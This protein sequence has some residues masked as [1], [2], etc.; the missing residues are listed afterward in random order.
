MKRQ[1]DSHSQYY[2]PFL[3]TTRISFK[4][5]KFKYFLMKQQK[6]ML[7]YFKHLPGTYSKKFKARIILG[8]NKDFT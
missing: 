2:F 4:K 8:K 1:T 6:K 3:A 5:A 7:P